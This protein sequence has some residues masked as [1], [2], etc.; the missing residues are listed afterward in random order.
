M[1][2]LRLRKLKLKVTQLVG[3]RVG[4]Q[5]MAWLQSL[6]LTLPECCVATIRWQMSTSEGNV[7]ESSAVPERWAFCSFSGTIH[8]QRIIPCLPFTL[9]PSLLCWAP[10][11]AGGRAAMG[12]VKGSSVFPS[13]SGDLFILRKAEHVYKVGHWFSEDCRAHCLLRGNDH[14]ICQYCWE[15]H[16][17]PWNTLHNTSAA[18]ETEEGLGNDCMKTNWHCACHR[19][20]HTWG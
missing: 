15:S 11:D 10:G 6:C 12:W 19:C 14:D 4:T 20:T 18:C 9:L 2:K 1:T 13:V 8:I 5:F 16:C 3:G 17:N 7:S